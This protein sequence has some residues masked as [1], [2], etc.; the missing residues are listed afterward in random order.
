MKELIA[1]VRNFRQERDWDKYH[2]PKNLVMALMVEVSELAEHFQ[3]LTEEESNRLGPDKLMEVREEIGDVLI[4]LANICD[5]L[6][7]DPIEAAKDKL[8]K[9]SIKYPAAEVYG[10][11]KK[12]SEYK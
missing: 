10:K 8:K 3:W 1:Q 9:N 11:S 2:S 12:Y 7:I 5:K 6:D 4:Y